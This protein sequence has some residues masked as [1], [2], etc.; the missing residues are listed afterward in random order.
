[1]LV[2]LIPTVYEIGVG[3]VNSFMLLGL[4][5]TWRFATRGHERAAGAIAAVMTAVKLTPA[6]LVWW[7][8]MTGRRRA[9]AAAIV[10]GLV[11]LGISIVGAGLES[12]LQYLR[13]LGDGGSIGTSPL[14]LA[15][16][17]RFV[18][19]PASVADRLPTSFAL[20]GLVA[21]A[22]LRN[23][24]AAA[25]CVAVITMLYGSPAVSINWY[26]L[27]YA[28]LA[29]VAWPILPVVEAKAGRRVGERAEV[30]LPGGV[31]RLTAAGAGVGA[32]LRS[33]R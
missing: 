27:L 31:S 18:G 8:L 17:A 14:S 24:P 3:N 20:A 29:P 25:F 16:M 2:L 26:I 6:M 33:R 11:V 10:T 30:R 23:R 32:G 15:G 12:H 21:V 28:L 5:L 4:I 19:V 7:L 13:I 1:M 22:V 9:V